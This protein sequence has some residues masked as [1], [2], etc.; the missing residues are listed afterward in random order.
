MVLRHLTVR[1]DVSLLSGVLHTHTKWNKTETSI[2]VQPIDCRSEMH[3]NNFMKMLLSLLL[4]ADMEN[5]KSKMPESWW[6]NAGVRA[7]V[8]AQGHKRNRNVVKR[9]AHSGLFIFVGNKHQ[10]RS[11]VISRNMLIWI[12]TYA[13]LCVCAPLLFRMG[14]LLF[15][16]FPFNCVLVLHSGELMLFSFS[17]I[18]EL[19]DRVS[20]FDFSFSIF[21]VD[22]MY[23]HSC[24][25]PL[26]HHSHMFSPFFET[27]LFHYTAKPENNVENYVH[28]ALK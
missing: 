18:L 2:L 16:H 8:C 7:R 19:L 3:P 28:V 21:G 12:Y 11:L 20:K 22:V 26:P 17:S 27:F 9:N 4:V 15:F 13:C 24:A 23:L 25:L 6:K 10:L 14:S 5:E 1:R